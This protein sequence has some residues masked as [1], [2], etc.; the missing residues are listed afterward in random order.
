MESLHEKLIDIQQRLKVP[1]DINNDFGGFK[2]RNLEDIEEKIKPFLK[3]HKLTLTFDDE[4]VLVGER[5]YV[6]STAILSDGKDTK[7]TSAFARE[8]QTPKAKMDDAQL[9]GSCSSY[10]RKYAAGGLFLIDE[11][12]DADSRDNTAP[13]VATTATKEQFVDL[14][15]EQGNEPASAMQKG[16]ITSLLKRT[17]TN[18]DPDSI[19]GAILLEYGV[20]PLKMTKEQAREII[21]KLNQKVT[22]TSK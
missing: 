11:T 22:E 7:T 6:K 13:K 4:I 16:T 3:E 14:L 18:N 21:A 10:A 2:Y 5:I 8:A 17:G 9:T 1:K 19:K 12:K 20:D 15:E